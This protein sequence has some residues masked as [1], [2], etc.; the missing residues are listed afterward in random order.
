MMQR[1]VAQSTE[2][3]KKT[4]KSQPFQN[5]IGK[6]ERDVAPAR[7]STTRLILRVPAFKHASILTRI[8]ELP[9]PIVSL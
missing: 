2:H 1:H 4:H 5:R 6:Q 3:S 7:S 9:S 8:S